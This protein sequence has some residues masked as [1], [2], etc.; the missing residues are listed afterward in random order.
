MKTQL[1]NAFIL[2]EL[3]VGRSIGA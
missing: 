2:I 3:S 1:V